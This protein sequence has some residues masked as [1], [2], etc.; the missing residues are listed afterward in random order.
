MF[1]YGIGG[2]TAADNNETGQLDT[3]RSLQQFIVLK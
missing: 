2:K 1:Y 3:L